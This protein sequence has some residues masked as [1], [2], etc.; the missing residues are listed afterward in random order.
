MNVLIF[1]SGTLITLTIAGLEEI[2]PALKKKTDIV[3]LLTPAVKYEVIK[4]PIQTKKF[5]LSALKLKNL[6]DKGIIDSPSVLKIDQDNLDSLTSEIMNKVNK[7]FW[8]RERPMNL[9]QKG[10][11][12]CL[13][14]YQILEKDKRI[15]KVAIAVDE[16]TTRMLGEK[17]ENLHKLLEKKLHT[18]IQVK[19][20]LNQ[21]KKYNFIRSAELV[22]IAYKKGIIDLKNGNVLD[23]LLYAT[24]FA[25]CSIS[26]EEINEIKKLK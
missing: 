10:E 2:L 7:T 14:L 12:S 1:D 20:N 23:S 15:K 5:A 9:I 13:A 17:P 11:S 26:K 25:G 8:A 24:K 4:R 18:K 19:G 21:F 6:L 3:F 22:Y 16:R